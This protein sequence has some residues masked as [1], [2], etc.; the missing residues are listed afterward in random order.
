MG[1]DAAM[2]S[3]RERESEKESSSLF[4][5]PFLHSYCQQTPRGMIG[6]GKHL[7]TRCRQWYADWREVGARWSGMNREGAGEGVPS[8][9]YV[10]K[11]TPV[12][13]RHKAQS[14]RGRH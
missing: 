14:N 5:A 11:E 1:T 10:G 2:T 7:R 9:T 13:G 8:P 4:V 12:T 3:A 6:G